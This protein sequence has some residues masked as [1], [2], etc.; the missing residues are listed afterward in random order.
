MA[1]SSAGS[2]N[3]LHHT[4]LWV[5]RSTE[6]GAEPGAFTAPSA[7]DGPASKAATKAGGAG[8]GVTLTG[9]TSAQAG[10]TR[11]TRRRA[12][13][14]ARSRGVGPPT[15]LPAGRGSS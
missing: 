5:A 11:V 8:G 9:R 1:P 12:I 15:A 7:L 2:A 6:P 13:G 3:A 14:A 4:A 10:T